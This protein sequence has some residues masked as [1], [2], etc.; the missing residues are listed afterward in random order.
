MSKVEVRRQSNSFRFVEHAADIAFEA[1]GEDLP[2]LFRAAAAAWLKATVNNPGSVRRRIRRKVELEAPAADLVLFALLQELVYFKDAEN[3]LLH[4]GPLELVEHRGGW[5]LTG[6]LEGEA[7]D[8]TRHDL[9]A[10]IKAVTLHQ[11]RLE[12]VDGGW[13][14]HIILDV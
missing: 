2:S 13:H 9:R 1:W 14:C 4:V 7:A 8:P 6:L 10:D 5:R 3:L 11:F 12:R